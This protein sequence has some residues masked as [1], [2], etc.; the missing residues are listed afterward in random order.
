MF[1]V[2]VKGL[3]ELVAGFKLVEKGLLDYRQ[4]GAWK[5]VRSEFYKIMKDQFASEGSKGASG[6]WKALNPKYKAIKD[7]K[8]GVLPILQRT[9]RTYK[10]LTSQGSDT[11]VDE[12]AQEMT[13]GTKVPYA[14]YHQRGSGRLPRREI[15]SLT[16][17]QEK[18]LMKPI[19]TKLKQL[20]ANAKLKELR[21]F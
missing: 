21:G 9:K 14:P 4:L 12:S 5:A 3:N 17:A 11:V 2:E 1:T 8:Y 16:V 13:I 6:K 10:S 19:Q 20:V 18:Q 15:I 7:R